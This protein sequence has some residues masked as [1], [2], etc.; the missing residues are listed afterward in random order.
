MQAKIL[1]KRNFAVMRVR[2]KITF[3]VRVRLEAIETHRDAMRRLMVWSLRPRHMREAAR[4]VWQAADKIWMA[5]G[6]TATDY[7]FYTKRV[8]LIAVMKSTLAFWLNDNSL[9]HKDTWDFLDR[10][11]DDVMKLGKGI[12]VIKTVG[13]SD[14]MSFVRKRFSV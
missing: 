12:S 2:D 4:F 9:N 5:A 1:A 13:V 6:D 11:I 3:A 14:I 10:R 7:N 8:L